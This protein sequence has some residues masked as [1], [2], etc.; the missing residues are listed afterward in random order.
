MKIKEY[1]KQIS[2]Y[3]ELGLFS[4]VTF[5]S[6]NQVRDALMWDILQ[7]LKEINRKLK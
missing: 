4:G 5:N 3:L 1:M 7:E 6:Q 2:E